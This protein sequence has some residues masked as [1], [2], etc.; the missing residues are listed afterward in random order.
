L[1]LGCGTSENNSSSIHGPATRAR[2]PVADIAVNLGLK[3]EADL[4]KLYDLIA[5]EGIRCNMRAMS[6]DAAQIVVERADFLR[7]RTVVTNFVVRDRLTVRVYMSPNT[8]DSLLE[9]WE[10]GR[11]TREEE[12]KL[13]LGSFIGEPLRRENKD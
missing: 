8:A 9:V 10:K 3:H 11:K 7:A 5:L 4:L 6:L 2:P 12:Y 13:Y 1:L